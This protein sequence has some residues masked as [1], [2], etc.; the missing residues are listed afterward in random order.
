M[1]DRYIKDGHVHWRY[2]LERQTNGRGEVGY[3]VYREWPQA[4]PPV[5]VSRFDT[6][7]QAQDYIEGLWSA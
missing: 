5:L 7:R 4:I 6:E 1:S 2:W 3:A